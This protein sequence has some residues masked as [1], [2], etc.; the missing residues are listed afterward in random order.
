M[1][2]TLVLF[3]FLSIFVLSIT[4]AE[5]VHK[6]AKSSYQ[7]FN[8]N[9]EEFDEKEDNSNVFHGN[10]FPEAADFGEKDDDSLLELK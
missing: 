2:A 5:V 4:Y 9:K 8:G 3:Y 1:K 10:E 6:N 7:E